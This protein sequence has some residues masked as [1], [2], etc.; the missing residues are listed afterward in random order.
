MSRC[1]GG[2]VGLTLAAGM[3]L[4][5]TEPLLAGPSITVGADHARIV[6]VAGTP[7]A[8]VVGNPLFA[9][10]SVRQGVI[11]V[12]GRNFGATN[13][14]VL[15]IDGNQLASFDVN[16]TNVG[17]R[18][19]S[20]YKAGQAWSSVCAPMCEYTL[21]TGEDQEWFKVLN[22]QHTSKASQSA[23]ALKLGE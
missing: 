19:V 4:L 18:T 21:S 13:V 20:I 11:I 5:L 17:E 22:E 12:H 15:D 8:V 6:S 16:V 10:V 2:F 1:E 23:G 9:D 7:S 3:T 14:I